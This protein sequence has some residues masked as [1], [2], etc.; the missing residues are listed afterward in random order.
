MLESAKFLELS[1]D[2]IGAAQVPVSVPCLSSCSIT[3]TSTIS[4]SSMSSISSP[5]SYLLQIPSFGRGT[6]AAI[7]GHE[8]QGSPL[9]NSLSSPELQPIVPIQSLAKRAR[10]FS[11]IDIEGT[12][13][14][15]EWDLIK[16]VL[17]LVG[18]LLILLQLP[19]HSLNVSK[20][21]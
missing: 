9:P 10:L 6:V 2:S 14:S 1:S 20:P 7:L 8:F 13:C 17:I 18:E 3:S 21:S 16:F 5:V 15:G 12:T 4:S 11:D 19:M